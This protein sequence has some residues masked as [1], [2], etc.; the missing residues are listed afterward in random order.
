MIKSTIVCEGGAA[1][2]KAT[3]VKESWLRSELS[4]QTATATAGP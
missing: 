4:Q 2:A 3:N 1:E